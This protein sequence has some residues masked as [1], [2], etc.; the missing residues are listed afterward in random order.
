MPRVSNSLPSS[1]Q[2]PPRRWI[3]PL[4]A[5]ALAIAL[6]AHT[7]GGTWIYDDLFH[8][9]DDP[10]LTQPGTWTQFLTEGYLPEGVDHLWRP[11]I[12][13]SYAVQ[14]KLSDRAWPFHLVNILLHAA[15]SALVAELAR[16]L[17]ASLKIAAI[18]GL[19]FAAHPLHVEAVAY[20]VGRAESAC[21]VG[22]LAAMVLLL[23]PMT[24]ARALAVFA[25][26][27]VAILSK[28]QGLLLPPM[29]LLLWKL[30]PK[31]I[32]AGPKD[33]SAG[34]LLLLLIL[35]TLAGYVIYREHILPWYWEP[36]HLDIATQP[37][38]RSVLRDRI[39]IPI[40][41]LG[42][43]T[44]LFVAPLKLSPDYGLAIITPR[45]SLTDPFL[46]LGLISLIAIAIA[47]FAFIRRRAWT[48][49]FLLACAALA[50]L[51]VSNV[52]LIGVVFAERLLY[53]PS[54][55]LLILAAM[56]LA[57]LPRKATTV[58]VALLLIGWSI[59]TIT[60]AARWNNRRSFYETTVAENPRA[61]RLRVLLAREYM[62]IGDYTRARQI[63]ED[64]LTTAPEYWKLWITAARIALEQNRLDD[65]QIALDH[66]VQ[67]DSQV[68]EPL[69][70]R[71][72]LYNRRLATQPATK[73]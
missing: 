43:S 42:R 14:I 61:A 8:A 13:L 31:L 12:S 21:T 56:A 44:A 1:L 36:E 23:R 59:R 53:L 69:D 40:A 52:K 28:E 66:A 46:Y 51:M 19:I 55:F 17:T 9:H 7:L 71:E 70:I 25:C 58:I 38:V 22:M 68:L 67:D 33:A 26:F 48:P 35:F 72:L 65:A 10:R 20:I 60:Y 45:Q 47:T 50:Y 49:L 41:L 15:A 57:K 6:Y 2:S 39:L 32:N 3:A 11:L 30:R 29:L 27:I 63:V 4:L 73:P 5:A 18:A 24:N 37:M 16:R 54:A 64:G 34:R 62:S